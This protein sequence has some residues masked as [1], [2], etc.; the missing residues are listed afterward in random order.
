MEKGLKN[1]EIG[2]VIDPWFGIVSDYEDY[3]H[4]LFAK[5]DKWAIQQKKLLE[6]DKATSKPIL[7]PIE[8][9]TIMASPIR[10]SNAGGLLPP[11]MLK[12][13]QKR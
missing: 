9:R 7:T 13:L 1:G 8:Y 6:I 4:Y 2:W 11:E 12:L 10:F 5:T 3:V